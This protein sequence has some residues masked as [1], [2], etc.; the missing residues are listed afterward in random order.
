MPNDK[1]M[2]YPKYIPWFG[3]KNSLKILLIEGPSIY[4]S[5]HKSKFY[6]IC[7]SVILFS[8]SLQNN[9]DFKLELIFIFK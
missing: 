1:F 6:I 3:H 9:G 4:L 8:K 5:I 2:K 7:D